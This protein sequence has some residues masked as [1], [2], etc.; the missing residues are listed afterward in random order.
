VL[1]Q[2]K[3]PRSARA[4]V[5]NVSGIVHRPVVT[6]VF[7]RLFENLDLRATPF[8]LCGVAPG[9]RLQMGALDCPTMHFVRGPG[10]AADQPQPGRQHRPQPVQPRG[11]AARRSARAP[12]RTEGRPGGIGGGVREPEGRDCAPARRSPGERDLH[13]ACGRVEATYVGGIGL[14]D[15]LPEAIVLEFSDSPRMRRTSRT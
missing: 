3:V 5:F 2:T 12:E 15:L 9:W 14:F 8:A 7:E 4:L 11:G 10:R 1:S 13:V 6:A